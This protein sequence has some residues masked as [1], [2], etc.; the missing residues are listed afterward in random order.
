MNRGD[1]GMMAV[2]AALSLCVAAC[3]GRD[4]PPGDKDAGG[5]DGP[6]AVDQQVTPDA[7]AAD[8][9]LP[10]LK[11]PDRRLPDLAI[12]DQ[13]R[14]IDPCG[15]GATLCGAVCVN[16]STNPQ[17]CGKCDAACKSGQVCTA[18]KCALTCRAALTDCAGACV[19][20][21][22]DH[23]NCGKCGA[24]C[25][26]GQLCGA[27]KCTLSCQAGLTDCGGTCVDLQADN[28][29]CGKCG[30]AC[31]AGFVC[32][33]SKCALSCQAGLTDCAGTCV[34]LQ[35][36]NANCGKCGDACKAGFVCSAGKCALS[37]QAGLTDCAGSCANLQTD[38]TN[39]GKCGDACKAG[40]VCSA[41]KCALSCQAGLTDCAGACTNLLA[42]N[43]NCGK[44]GAACPLGASCS[45][46]KCSAPCTTGYLYCNTKCVDANNDVNNCGKCGTKCG[47]NQPCI[48]GSCVTGP[49]CAK[50]LAA[51]PTAKDGVY[52]IKPSAAAPSF[53]VYCDMT[54]HHGGW[55]LVGKLGRT[56]HPSAKKPFDSDR[57]ASHLLSNAAPAAAVQANLDLARFNAWGSGW[58]IRTQVDAHNNGKHYQYTFYRTRSG[59]S[60]LPATAGKNWLGSTTASKL[61]HLTMSS[62]T[63]LTNSTWLPVEKWDACCGHTFMLFGYRMAKY[64]SSY[65]CLTG[66]KTTYCHGVAGGIV[67]ENSSAIAGSYTAAFGYSDKVSH[68]HGRQ[69]YYWIKDV[70][71]AGTP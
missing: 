53:A 32:S 48:K 13:R 68:A 64:G 62:T 15:P 43:A 52:T 22:A 23:A 10:D 21:Q 44:C 42:D 26:P 58:T 17:H 8:L 36:D 24:A 67:N 38:N 25:G 11:L 3:G 20:L 54:A 37:C 46:G 14:D 50:I 57:N 34:D 39:C 27:G 56:V 30:D 45:A 69:A 16:T 7:R 60:L 6:A 33:A 28:A 5:A 55:V 47:T 66:G 71:A 31:K 63:G 40:F 18:G 4:D 12:P 59:A 70:N 49:S 65:Q 35:A 51:Y 41:G 61:Q 29:N 19:N 1:F 9:K 2:A